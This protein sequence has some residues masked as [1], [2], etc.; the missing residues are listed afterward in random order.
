MLDNLQHTDHGRRLGP[1]GS[2]ICQHHLLRPKFSGGAQDSP[3]HYRRFTLSLVFHSHRDIALL[4]ALIDV[5]MGVGHLL[6][7]VAP[8]NDRF[9]LSGFN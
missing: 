3:G 7:R 8:I 1:A 5:P 2:A 6:E 4:V 9:E